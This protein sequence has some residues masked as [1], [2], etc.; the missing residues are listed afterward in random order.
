MME[1][2]YF[3]D[4][5]FIYD[6]ISYLACVITIILMTINQNIYLEKNKGNEDNDNLDIVPNDKKEKEKICNKI[7]DALVNFFT[8][9]EFLL[10]FIR[11]LSIIWMSILRNFFSLGIFAF[12]FFSFIFDDMNNISYL[13]IFILIPTEFL[14]IGCLHLCNINGI[15]ESLDNDQKNIYNDFA[16]EKEEYNY[17][18]ILVGI[19]FLFIVIFLNSFYYRKK[20]FKNNKINPLFSSND[21]INQ[22]KEPLLIMENKDIEKIA[23]SEIIEENELYINNNENTKFIDFGL[24]DLLLKFIYQNIGKLTLI[25][26]YFISVH[27]INI[28]HF[29][30]IIIFMIQILKLSLARKYNKLIIILLQ[31]LFLFEYIIEITKNY[32]E[33]FFVDNIKLFEFLLSVSENN[34]IYSININI[35]IL[36]Y[37]SIYSFYFENKIINTEKYKQL[38]NNKDINILFYIN[39]KIEKN[40]K[41]NAYSI[42]TDIVFDIY[43]CLIFFIFFILCCNNEINKFLN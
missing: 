35:E 16:Y 21:S 13:V 1:K 34:K 19:Y 20:K 15:S 3:S 30:N 43:I 27:T 9:S 5:T 17:K 23:D 39:N 10:F 12:L 36:C 2:Y 11:I 41:I 8:N 33:E 18:Y 40:W 32:Y 42:I 22:S 4:L 38:I 25:T 24:S 31:L 28:V 7:K 6:W 26:M 14:T 29:I 37:V